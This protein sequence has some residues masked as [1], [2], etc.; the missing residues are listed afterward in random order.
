MDDP[1]KYADR[2][3]RLRKRHH[4]KEAYRLWYASKSPEY[5]KKRQEEINLYRRMG[6]TAYKTLRLKRWLVPDEAWNW[7]A[8]VAAQKLLPPG[9]VAPYT[10]ERGRTQIVRLTTAGRLVTATW[11]FQPDDPTPPPLDELYGMSEKDTVHQA[12]ML[13]AWQ[14]MLG[15][16]RGFLA[17]FMDQAEVEV[18]LLSRFRHRIR[19]TYEKLERWTKVFI[20][21]GTFLGW[22]EKLF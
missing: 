16:R 1:R 2:E 8:L 4:R 17:C 7:W 18:L 13:E 9:V 19:W 20:G 10:D 11:P 5:K 6:R 15:G 21:Y 12:V 22:D 3:Y 14:R